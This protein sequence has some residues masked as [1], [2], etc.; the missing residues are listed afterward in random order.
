MVSRRTSSDVFHQFARLSSRLF[1]VAKLPAGVLRYGSGHT[2]FPM[3]CL[4]IVLQS[5]SCFAFALDLAVKWIAP[6]TFTG[7]FGVPD[8]L[9][10]S[11]GRATTADMREAPK[12]RVSSFMVNG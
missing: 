9:P 7:L 5:A 11:E 3:L 12:R 10:E 8:L 1:A 2:S 6:G 4:Y